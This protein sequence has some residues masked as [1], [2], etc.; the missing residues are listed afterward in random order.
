V[1]LSSFRKKRIR[2]SKE[3]GKSVTH[4]QHMG[5][6]VT[7]IISSQLGQPLRR[8]SMGVCM[9]E[10]SRQARK[11]FDLAWLGMGAEGAV[12]AMMACN[13]QVWGENFDFGLRKYYLNADHPIFTSAL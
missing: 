10:H 2:V 6:S 5:W 3:K 11:F 4:F 1:S 7:C 13:T 9:M 12:D 8:K